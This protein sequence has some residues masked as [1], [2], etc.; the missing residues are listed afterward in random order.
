[1]NRKINKYNNKGRET[2]N[3]NGEIDMKVLEGKT[4][5]HVNG[6]LA[7]GIASGIKKDNKKDLCIIYSKYRANSAA[8]FTSNKVKAPPLLVDMQNIN[9]GNTQAI[10]INSG[11]SN[12]C[13]GKEGFENAKRMV[14]TAADFLDLT[15]VEVL[16][17]STGALGKQ[18][19]MDIVVPGIKRACMELSDKAGLDAAEAILST[20][21][22]TKTMA[23]EFEVQGKKVTMAG[24]TKGST[25][26]HPNMGT[27]LSFIVT[28]ASITKTLLYKALKESIDKSF[29]M[30]SIDGDTSTSDMSVILANG[31]SGIK[32]IDSE[33]EDYK[34]FSQVLD[35]V[36]VELAKMIAKDGEGST[37]FIE[38]EVIGAKTLAEARTAARSVVSSN[39]VKC[40]CFGSALK[41]STIAGA[42][43][44]CSI[45]INSENYD[46]FICNEKERVQVVKE[47]LETN[48]DKALLDSVISGGFIKLLIDLKLGKS[49]ATAWG[50]DLTYNYVKAN[51][52]LQ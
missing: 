34:V 44:C 5:T 9:N 50:C 32:C 46:I 49:K 30:L 7:A 38:V 52:Y 21:T 36:A 37:K 23:V 14:E 17:A 45:N 28:D 2:C 16:V 47:A 51:G 18:L 27:T 19:P 15:S 11:N 20:D 1:L 29:N 26:I 31:T 40:E 10:V 6:F 13:T 39:L 25:M 24:M 43:G 12:A 3:R 33:N 22:K 42:L 41:W 8:V 4:I 48:Y 35:Y